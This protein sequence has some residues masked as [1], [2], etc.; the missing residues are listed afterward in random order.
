MDLES[1]LSS[2]ID[3][4]DIHAI[5]DLLFNDNSSHKVSIKKTIYFNA[6]IDNVLNKFVDYVCADKSIDVNRK[7]KRV[8]VVMGSRADVETFLVGIFQTKESAIDAAKN[9]VNSVILGMNLQP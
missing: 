4:D 6:A 5:E 1:A 9:E 2:K 8:Y 7:E 3:P